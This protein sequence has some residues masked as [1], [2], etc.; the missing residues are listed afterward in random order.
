MSLELFHGADPSPILAALQR[1]CAAEQIVSVQ[2][3]ADIPAVHSLDEQEQWVRLQ[4]VLGREPVYEALGI[5]SL[6]VKRPARFYYATGLETIGTVA[7]LLMRGGVRARFVDDYK[8]A[9]ILSQN[10]LDDAVLRRYNGVEAYSCS[11]P[12]CEW[13]IGE[14][15]LDETVLL[16]SGEDWWLLA[17][18]GTD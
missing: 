18:T 14:G 15:P 5:S 3:R 8:S 12:W 4:L 11:Y 17:V 6:P 7:N 10:F 1:D 16:G 2:F 9:L 13:F